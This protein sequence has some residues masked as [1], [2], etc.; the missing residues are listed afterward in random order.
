MPP[1][2]GPQPATRALH[3]NLMAMVWMTLSGATG[4]AMQAL[5]RMTAD[6]LHTFEIVFVRNF[7]ALGFLTPFFIRQ[8]LAVLRTRQ[9]GIHLLRGAFQTG[10]MMLYWLSLTMI[11]LANATAILFSSPIF[12]TIA[13]IL[14]LGEPNMLRRWA[15][16]GIGFA[17]ML[18][19]VRPDAGALELGVAYAL[20]GSFF[21]SVSRTLAK[22]LTR[23]ES[24]PTVVALLAL[25]TAPFSLIFAAFVWRWPS[26]ETFAILLVITGFGT[27]TQLM[28]TQAYRLGE[29]TALEPFNFTRLI[30]ASLFGYVIFAEIP[31]IWT[32]IGGAVIVLSATFLAHLEARDLRGGAGRD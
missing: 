11:P 25:T 30:W 2:T 3:A 22:K 12:A 19:I 20:L 24:A 1:V 16:V 14:F 17:G 13:A 15:S 23:T 7:L 29:M 4:T 28:M 10:G 32:W 27:L 26:L 31:V 21:F 8:G 18:I 6:D 9:L 5:V